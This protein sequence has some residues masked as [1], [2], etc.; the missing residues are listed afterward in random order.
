MDNELTDIYT[1][2]SSLDSESISA[3]PASVVPMLQ[4]TVVW[5]PTVPT[6]VQGVTEKDVTSAVADTTG[7][8]TEIAIASG[9]ETETVVGMKLDV[10]IS[11]D[12]VGLCVK[13]LISNRIN[14]TNRER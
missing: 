13:A 7:L 6:S 12:T 1:A 3:A 4:V 14:K 8:V 5:K 11:G 2:L 9:I 10:Y